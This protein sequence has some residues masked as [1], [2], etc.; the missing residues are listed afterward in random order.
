[1][2]STLMMNQKQDNKGWRT[3]FDKTK[4]NTYDL[5]TYVENKKNAN[6]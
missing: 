6:T 1:M 3:R 4:Y 5:A 2:E